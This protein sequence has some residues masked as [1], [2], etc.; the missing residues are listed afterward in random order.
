MWQRRQSTLHVTIGRLDQYA[1][2]RRKH[3]D[4]N[5]RPF[6]MTNCAASSGQWRL[7]DLGCITPTRAAGC[8]TLC[9]WSF[10]HTNSRLPAA[11][12]MTVSEEP[13]QTSCFSEIAKQAYL[14]I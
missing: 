10:P 4:L 8:L 14:R 3:I 7:N 5:Q 6:G 13:A 1:Q 9:N 2:A 11:M 12:T